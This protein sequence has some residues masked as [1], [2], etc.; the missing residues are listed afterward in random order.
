[1]PAPNWLKKLAGSFGYEDAPAQ[2]IDELSGYKPPKVTVTPIEALTDGDESR[3]VEVE[4]PDDRSNAEKAL[5]AIPVLTPPKPRLGRQILGA[6][7]GGYGG[8]QAA[9]GRPEAAA[10]GF[11][12]AKKIQDGGFAQRAA[13]QARK[14]E[15]IKTQGLLED[16][17]KDRQQRAAQGAAYAGAMRDQTAT[18]AEVRKAQL[19]AKAQA[20]AQKLEADI[21]RYVPDTMKGLAKVV[22]EGGEVPDPALFTL[23]RKLGKVSVYV[24]N[25]KF[26]RDLTDADVTPE[27]VADFARLAASVQAP[28]ALQ[29]GRMHKGHYERMWTNLNQWL[30]DASRESI[31]ATGAASREA[32]ARIKGVAQKKADQGDPIAKQLLANEARAALMLQRQ[33][34]SV[35]LVAPPADQAAARA[36][37]QEDYN[38]TI[39]QLRALYGQK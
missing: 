3:T 13:D 14:I 27:E 37:A 26:M 38:N 4:G 12:A 5:G 20:D 22:R 15:L 35:D 28:L 9:A 8:W 19:E 34:G 2:T 18:N 24:P 36:K 32:V 30:K 11:E 1:M 21:L 16:Q 7:A 31:A 10:V 39:A 29:S 23:Q 17:N 33:S 6:L 25:E